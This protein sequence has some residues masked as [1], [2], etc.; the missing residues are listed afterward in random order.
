VPAPAVSG[1]ECYERAHRV[2]IITLEQLAITIPAMWHCGTYFNA[3]VLALLGL[4]FITGH[5]IYSIS[6]MGEPKSRT[7][8]FV[9]SFLTNVALLGC[10]L[11]GVI[12]QM[13]WGTLGLLFPD[14]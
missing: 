6:Y 1:D 10:S 4:A 11:Y 9:I 8:G 13:I 14:G 5:V 3:N 12:S 7:L 2:Q